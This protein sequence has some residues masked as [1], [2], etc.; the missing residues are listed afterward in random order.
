LALLSLL[1][2]LSKKPGEPSPAEAMFV[3]LGFWIFLAQSFPLP[4]QL[5]GAIPD[6]YY[7]K[8]PAACVPLPSTIISLLAMR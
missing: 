7:F 8:L 5:I 1:G 6:N 4:E 3:G 2:T